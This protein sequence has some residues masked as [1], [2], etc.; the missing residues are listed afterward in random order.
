MRKNE[1]VCKDV[2]ENIEYF[3][4]Y[5]DLQ[6]G[7]Q[8]LNFVDG[9]YIDDVVI[10][11]EKIK[12]SE[13]FEKYKEKVL[14]RIDLGISRYKSSDDKTNLENEL[15]IVVLRCRKKVEDVK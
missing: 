7:G 10:N 15:Y 9:V 6:L 3:M 4:E 14:D 8:Y 12:G 11:L 2:S 1:N 5:L 13:D